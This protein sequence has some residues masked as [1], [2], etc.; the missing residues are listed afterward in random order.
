MCPFFILSHDAH[1]D[2]NTSKQ[3][4]EIFTLP[5]VVL[6]SLMAQPRLQYALSKDGLLP[7]IFSY[8][9]NQGNI[10]YGTL[11]SGI[12]V[13]L[14]ASFVPFEHLND[15]ISAGILVAF[16]MT[17]SSL[18]IMRH[19]SPINEPGKVERQIAT[20]NIS[21]LIFGISLTHFH[22][23]IIGNLITVFS[24]LRMITCLKQLYQC[25]Q[26]TLFGGSIRA[27]QYKGS[28]DMRV[29]SY[30][31]T[32]MLP[33]FPCMGIFVNCYLIS[34]LEL[35][36]IALLLGYLS[37][38][39]IFY[40]CYGMQHSVGANGG[41]EEYDITPAQPQYDITSAILRNDDQLDSDNEQTHLTS[42]AEPPPLFNQPNKRKSSD[43]LL[44][45]P[46]L[47]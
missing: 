19:E 40:F 41:W 47:A 18:I 9:D 2:L 1:I 21:A 8:V 32:P 24:A 23:Y 37:A 13:V 5:I 31:K 35:V 46:Q 26:A 16:C 6:I 29:D 39:A 38:A 10:W 25:P 22:E 33:F 27:S 17:D 36:G 14:I 45:L 12:L 20:F 28:V 42:W 43:K 3:F 30:F 15:M 11:I 34:Q 7:G 44:N 4:G